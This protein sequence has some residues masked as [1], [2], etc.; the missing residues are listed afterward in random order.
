MK[1]LKMHEV[2]YKTRKLK[3]QNKTDPQIVFILAINKLWLLKSYWLCRFESVFLVTIKP[4]KHGSKYV[5]IYIFFPIFIHID[6]NLFIK[7]KYNIAP[8][9]S[10]TVV[11]M[12]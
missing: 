10:H 3:K 5:N 11:A 1:C 2:K 8:F 6:L 4:R 9:A 7:F 12:S